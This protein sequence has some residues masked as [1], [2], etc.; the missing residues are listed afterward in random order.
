MII[1]IFIPGQSKQFKFDVK[2]TEDVLNVKKL[3]HDKA[4]IDIKEQVL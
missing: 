3:I 1:T 4:K 2:R